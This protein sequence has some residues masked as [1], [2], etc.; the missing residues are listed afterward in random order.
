MGDPNSRANLLNEA[1]I[2]TIIQ[3]D[4]FRLW[5][6]R[7]CSADPKYAFL[8]VRRTADIIA[9]SIMAA[10]L[11][12]VDRNISRTYLEDVVEGV[13]NYMR[14]LRSIGAIID[15]EAYAD[16]DLNTPDQIEAGKVYIDFRFSANY[17]AE[18]ITFRSHLVNDYLAEVLPVAA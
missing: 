16:P 15:G 11:W 4:G 12:A 6:N 9:D 13:N 3:Q 14:H 18:H 17:P 5:G 7:T 8:N 2:T 10:H 1:G